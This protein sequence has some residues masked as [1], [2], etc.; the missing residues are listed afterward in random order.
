MAPE[1]LKAAAAASPATTLR[2]SAARSAH[3]GERHDRG[4][5]GRGVVAIAVRSVGTTTW[6]APAPQRGRIHVR[7]MPHPPAGREGSS[8][9]AGEALT[10]SGRPRRRG[11][12]YAGT[13]IQRLG[14]TA[15]VKGVIRPPKASGRRRED[16]VSTERTTPVAITGA[17]P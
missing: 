7:M 9:E 17:S 13:T 3:R 12:G 2:G 1:S 16:R 14:G 8:T 4:I 15:A 6:L 11:V 10:Q 5:S